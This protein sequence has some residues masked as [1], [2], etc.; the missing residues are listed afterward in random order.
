MLD[1]VESDL[2]AMHVM[3]DTSSDLQRFISSPIMGREDQGKGIA[4][5]AAAAGV[6]EL[7]AKFLGTLAHN[8][9][10]F[11]LPGVIKAFLAKLS[12]RRG[13]AVAEVV[14]AH[15]LSEAQTS[16][17]VSALAASVG[18]RVK[19]DVRVDPSLIGGLVV[20]VGSHMVD[21]SIRAKLQRLQLSMK[22]VG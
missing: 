14:A 13:E 4:A 17:I 2:K 10:L 15:P 12:E 11:T 20:K 18:G 19:V 22:G 8:R 16:A 9:R 21:S 3:L 6:S 1:Q 7:S 5:L